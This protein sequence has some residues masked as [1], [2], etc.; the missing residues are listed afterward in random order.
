M[1]G[2]GRSGPGGLGTG[3]LLPHRPS[4]RPEGQISDMV[5]STLKQRPLNQAHLVPLCDILL[6][7]CLA[8][9]VHVNGIAQPLE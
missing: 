2:S 8:R 9:M 6:P 1:N 4:V 5:H 7:V 3:G